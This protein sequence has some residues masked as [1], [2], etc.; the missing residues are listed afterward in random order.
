[1]MSWHTVQGVAGLGAGVLSL[2]AFV[3]YTISTIRKPTTRPNRA[4]WWIWSLVGVL[5]AFGNYSE[6]VRSGIWLPLSYII[7]PTV[8]AIVSLRH[9]EGGW[10]RLDRFCLLGAVASV[11]FWVLT[12]DPLGALLINILIDALGALPTIKKS[13]KN[14]EAEDPIFWYLAFGATILNLFAVERFS[15]SHLVY[16]IYMFLLMGTVSWFELRPVLRRG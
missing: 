5:I 3:P 12:R 16:P 13:Y 7:G 11:V 4:T 14:P 9:G 8:L 6:G 2:A 10:T 15:F 1:M